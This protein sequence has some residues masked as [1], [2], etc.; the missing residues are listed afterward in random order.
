MFFITFG[1]LWSLTIFFYIIYII[2]IFSIIIYLLPIYQNN[3]VYNNFNKKTFFTFVSAINIFWVISA[4]LIQIFFINLLWSSSIFVVWF[5]HLIIT[6]FQFKILY[7]QLLLFYFYILFYTTVV[8]FTSRELYD[9]LIV[10]FQ[11]LYWL[12]LI[13]YTN[14]LFSMVFVIEVLSI[15]ILLFIISSTFSSV[16]FYNNLNNNYGHLNQFLIPTTFIQTILYIY[17]ISLVTSLLLFLFLIL[18]YYKLYSFDYYLIEYIFLFFLKITS[19]YEIFSLGIIW[20]FFITL[21][22]I[23]CGLAPFFFWKPAFFKGIPLLTLSFYIYYYYFFMF[24]YV[25]YLMLI[26]LS[27][28]F[29]FYILIFWIFILIGLIV[30]CCILCETYYLKSFLAVS[31]ILNSLLMFLTLAV[32]YYINFFVY[33]V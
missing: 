21:F 33:F 19:F 5:G 9:N 6:N 13:F 14:T 7:F 20:M 22:F 18:F 25:L 8:Y 27:E 17:W 12:I 10:N 11:F 29:Y 32:P 15:L 24:V 23:K 30:L 28:I 26:Y 2:L 4:I 16:F 3:S 1:K 31:S